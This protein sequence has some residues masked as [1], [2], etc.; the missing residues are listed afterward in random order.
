M[1]VATIAP[2]VSTFENNPMLHRNEW[3]D[4][5]Q[6]QG[7]VVQAFKPWRRDGLVLT[8]DTVTAIASRLGK[9]PSQVCLRWNMQKGNAVVFKSN[10]PSHISEN[11]DVSDFELSPEDMA[12]LDAL[13][14]DAVRAEAQDDWEKRRNGTSAP[15]G[16]GLRPE[17]RIRGAKE[18]C[19]S[20]VLANNSTVAAAAKMKRSISQKETSI[21]PGS[22]AH[23]AL[24]RAVSSR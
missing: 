22:P 11:V 6:E 16:D 9:C 23:A 24:K 2:V 18:K 1:E 12:S 20:L 10:R 3:V 13:T 19:L 4:F 21:T 7:V 8:H 17:K 15:W 14:T 5:F